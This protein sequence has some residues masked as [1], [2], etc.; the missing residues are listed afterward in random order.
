MAT[1]QYVYLNA[2]PKNY[3]TLSRDQPWAAIASR[4]QGIAE[5]SRLKTLADPRRVIEVGTLEWL[6]GESTGIQFDVKEPKVIVRVCVGAC[7]QE[8]EAI[9]GAR[10]LLVREFFD[11]VERVGGSVDIESASE[12][13]RRL[14]EVA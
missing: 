9:E 13:M 2:T 6:I 11:A 5:E 7:Y 3:P 4:F 14:A 8:V 12:Q 1:I 10:R